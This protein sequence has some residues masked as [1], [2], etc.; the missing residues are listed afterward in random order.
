[1]ST[2]SRYALVER[3]PVSL[4]CGTL[5]LIAL[6]VLFFSR[7]D[8]DYNPQLETEIKRLQTQV[9]ALQKSID[10]QDS[11]LTRIEQEIRRRDSNNRPPLQPEAPAKE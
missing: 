7:H 8:S 10:D 11:K 6:I 1:M 2:V 9:S 4:G 3:G 5:I